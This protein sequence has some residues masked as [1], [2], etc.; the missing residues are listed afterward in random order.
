M[1]GP[2][3]Q[4]AEIDG[5]SARST[6]AVDFDHHRCRRFGQ[7]FNDARAKLQRRIE[8]PRLERNR[9]INDGCHTA[10]IVKLTEEASGRL[11]WRAEGCI[12][13]VYVGLA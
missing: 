6:P 8:S 5:A 12:R 4:I 3:P 10:F 1:V 9:C 13:S 11:Y 2:S 7:R